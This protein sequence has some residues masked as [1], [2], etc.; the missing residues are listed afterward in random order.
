VVAACFGD[1]HSVETIRQLAMTAEVIAVALDFGGVASL[2]AM[3]D[4]ALSAGALRCHALDV[5]EEFACEALLPALHAG[6]IGDPTQTVAGLAVSFAARKLDE[7]A[8]LERAAVSYPDRVVLAMRR[9]VAP[10]LAPT[11]VDIRFADGM[12]VSINGVEMT[13]TELME[14]LETITGER[15]LCVLDREMAR[16]RESQPA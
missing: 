8:R 4:L 16:S 5:R 15:A 9:L 7:I 3:R 1:E 2:G 11:Q 12:P 13:L 6:A 10:A 14:S